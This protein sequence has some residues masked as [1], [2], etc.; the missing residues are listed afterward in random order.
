MNFGDLGQNRVS[1][2][3][4]QADCSRLLTFG[5][6]MPNK[7]VSELDRTEGANKGQENGE[8]VGIRYRPVGQ[9]PFVQHLSIT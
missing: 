1:D 3:I 5:W 2:N 7:T 9:T 6:L 8:A 4:G